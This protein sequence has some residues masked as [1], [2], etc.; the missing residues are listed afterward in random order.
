MLLIMV[1]SEVKYIRCVTFQCSNDLGHE[2]LILI[3]IPII[4]DAPRPSA[5]G[6]AHTHRVP[7]LTIELRDVDFVI[8]SPLL[9]IASPS[10]QGVRNS[11]GAT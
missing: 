11:S 2:V 1:T 8:N 4:G 10:H 7:G 6:L 3:I 9:F 5:K